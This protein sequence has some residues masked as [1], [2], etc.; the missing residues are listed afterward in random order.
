MRA[1]YLIRRLLYIAPTL[2]GALTFA[3]AVIHLAPGDPLDVILG[4]FRGSVSREVID[5][6]RRQYGLDRPLPYQYLVFIWNAVRGNFGTSLA[7]GQPVFD[8]ILPHL[9]PTLMLAGAGL[10]VSVVLGVPSGITAALKRNT[11]FD[12]GVMSLAVLWLSAPSFWFGILLIYLLGYRLPLFPMFGGG[13]EG[14][15]ASQL[16]HL[17]LPAIALGARSAALV[18]RI[19]RSATLDVLRQDYVRTARAKGLPEPLVIAKHVLRNAAIPI[20]TVLGLDLA[21][22][23]GGSV[24]VEA[25]F[26]RPGLGKTMVDA[27]FNR[28]YPVVQ[29]SILLFIC[30]VVLVNFL[31]DVSYSLID[32]RLL[33]D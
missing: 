17:V 6:L 9:K 2:L 29:G 24:I 25:M 18:A 3:F 32:R 14:N 21:Y 15:L 22:L 20:I 33:F 26:A 12:Y 16:Y 23:L 4:D 30:A 11:L 27:I 8:L 1:D 5:G 28:D 13:D 10:V 19:S 7:S 31:T